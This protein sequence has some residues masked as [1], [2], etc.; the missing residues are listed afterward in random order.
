MQQIDLGSAKIHLRHNRSEK[1][2]LR[3]RSISPGITALKHAV[4]DGRLCQTCQMTPYGE[5]Q[6]R[7]GVFFMPC[8]VCS[9]CT[10]D[11]GRVVN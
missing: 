7:E 9:G 10:M 8:H 11:G 3:G 6:C 5:R 2:T 4:N 1:W